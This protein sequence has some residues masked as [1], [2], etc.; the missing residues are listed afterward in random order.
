VA[1]VELSRSKSSSRSAVRGTREIRGSNPSVIEAALMRIPTGVLGV[2]CT[3]SDVVGG[4]KSE[5]GRARC[6][7]GKLP[8]SVG[9]KATGQFN[10][11]A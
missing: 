2:S 7:V 6:E 4:R 8:G 9:S 3:N 10:Q 5:A 1:A 11:T